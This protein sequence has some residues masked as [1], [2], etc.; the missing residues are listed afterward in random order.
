MDMEKR[1]IYN[2]FGAE[3]AE[4]KVPIDEYRVLMEVSIFYVAWGIMAFMLTL[5]KQS[6]TARQWV[7]TGAIGLMVVEVM[8]VLKEVV[9][10]DWVLPQMTEHELIMLG[11]NLFPAYLNGCR[12]IGAYLYVDV[13]G[14]TRALLL[15][16]AEQNKDVLV[17]L[18][19]L[20]AALADG[21]GFGNGGADAL[22]TPTVSQALKDVE[23]SL[24]GGPPQPHPGANLL[25]ADAPKSNTNLYLM[26]AGYVVLYYVFQGSGSA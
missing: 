8:L 11:H 15:A 4:S 25:K 14:H 9:L 21:G 12:C 20:K 16:L 18:R 2:R 3:K 10:P 1:D 19:E 17:A 26:I 6:S 5:G 13:D 22:P 7:F 24:R 23:A